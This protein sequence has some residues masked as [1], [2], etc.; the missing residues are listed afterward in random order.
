MAWFRDIIL[1]EQRIRALQEGQDA[2]NLRVATMKQDLTGLDRDMDDLNSYVKK[3]LGRIT[4]GMRRAEEP[5]K[6][7]INEQIRQGKLGAIRV[8]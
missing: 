4:G 2:L 7:D 8:R 1:R 5:D 3:S 6:D